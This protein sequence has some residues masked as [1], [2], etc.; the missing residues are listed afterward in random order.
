M[1]QHVDTVV[2]RTITVPV[3]QQRAF[4]LFTSQLGRWWPREYSIGQSPM[5]DFILE[6]R[7]GGRWYE[8]GEDDKQCDTGR[9]TAFE[10]P[11]RIVLAWHLNGQ[12]QFDPDPTHA[13]EVEVRFVVEGS[14]QTRVEVEHRGFERHGADAGA[15]LGSVDSPTGWTYCLELFAKY[16]AA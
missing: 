5:V 15:V 2:L 13:S 1:T 6:P 14:T 7:I 10:P 9:V 4:E 11:S 8:V 16:A 12:F 3:S